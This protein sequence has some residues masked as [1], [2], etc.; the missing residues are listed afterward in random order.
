MIR[1]KYKNSMGEEAAKKM[2]TEEYWNDEMDYRDRIEALESFH[3]PSHVLEFAKDDFKYLPADVQSKVKQ[4][5]GN[6]PF[7]NGRQKAL[8][9][10]NSKENA[11][12]I[13]KAAVTTDF[14]KAQRK[15]QADEEKAKKD[16]EK[17][18]DVKNSFEDGKMKAENHIAQRMKNLGMKVKEERTNQKIE[19]NWE[20][21]IYED[22]G[23]KIVVDGY[24]AT[25]YG[26][27]GS[28]RQVMS[29]LMI[30]TPGGQR[31]K[32]YS[33]EAEREFTEAMKKEGKSPS[34]SF[35]NRSFLEDE[36][37]NEARARGKYD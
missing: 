12:R 37:D 3:L 17:E 24:T 26:I 1:T 16:K 28:N 11:D 30:V 35:P 6:S 32:T 13:E 19:N 7:A 29:R 20:K 33:W 36:E 4:K 27:R 5:F 10:I 2:T 22:S 8:S 14:F 9:Y 23:F 31:K 34:K 25:T 18:Y 15:R 21:V